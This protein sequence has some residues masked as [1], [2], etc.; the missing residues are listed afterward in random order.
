MRNE[1]GVVVGY[2][3]S[4]SGRDAL[5]WAAVEA[6]GRALPLTICNAW[7]WP[8][9]EWPGELV[10]LELVRSP[11]MRLVKDA[12]SWSRRHHPKMVVN[13]LTDRGTAAHILTD[14]SR[15]AALIVVGT[16]G[17]GSVGGLMAGSVSSH[18]AAHARCPVIVVRG[19]PDPREGPVV[20]GFDGSPSS[21]AA[22]R[23][24]AEEAHLQKAPLKVVIAYREHGAEAGAEEAR[25]QAQGRA[26]EEL[27]WSRRGYPDLEADVELVDEPARP[28]LLEAGEKARL[29]VVGPRGMGEIRGLLLGSVSQAMVHQAP[30]P[31]AVVHEP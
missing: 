18:V 15:T 7:E 9:H 30:C 16:R 20:V 14:L 26:W 31:V 4:A 13:T 28:A 10:P 11:A 23:F 2:D 27:T 21:T 1:L 6:E 12:A 3:G 8:H 19:R 22:L 29:L 25:V 17:Y 5:C 24:A